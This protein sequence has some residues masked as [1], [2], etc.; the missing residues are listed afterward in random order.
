M[1]KI[2]KKPKE[3]FK[4]AGIGIGTG[5]TV[6]NGCDQDHVDGELQI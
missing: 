4:V 2:E 1:G 6:P 5:I 3:E